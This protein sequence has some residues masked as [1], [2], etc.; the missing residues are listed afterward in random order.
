MHTNKARRVV[1]AT[2]NNMLVFELSDSN[3]VK[4]SNLVSRTEVNYSAVYEPF[5]CDFALENGNRYASRLQNGR[6]PQPTF[7]STIVSLVLSPI[8]ID[9]DSSSLE[10]ARPSIYL[11]IKPDN[12]N[13]QTPTPGS[14]ARPT[15]ANI[16]GAGTTSS[17]VTGKGTGGKNTKHA[18]LMIDPV[19]TNAYS[20]SEHQPVR[21]S[22][23]RPL[24]GC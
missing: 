1:L 24:E 22:I 20:P 8:P 17:T 16:G 7:L 10:S 5:E 21:P 12:P 23:S 2:W 19:K 4:I 6:P 15:N 3:T 11:K 9:D 18:T 13:A 14:S